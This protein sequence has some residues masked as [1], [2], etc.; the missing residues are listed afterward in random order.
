MKKIRSVL[1]VDDNE[2]DHIIAS[3]AV[4][5]YD[6]D[7]E[8]HTAYDG[9]EALTL[10][11]SLERLPDII[12]LDLNMPGLDGHGFLAEYAKFEQRSAVVVM[13]TTSDQSSDREKCMSYSFVREYLVK[14]LEVSDLAKVASKI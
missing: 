4:E 7:V 11:A 10:L 3:L 2:A 9:A 5:E 13:L 6:A 14:P 8:I 1:I 12:L